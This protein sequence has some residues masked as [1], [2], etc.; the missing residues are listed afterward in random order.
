V[1]S[2][3]YWFAGE[4]VNGKFRLLDLDSCKEKVVLSNYD[5]LQM[6]AKAN[7]SLFQMAEEG[8]TESALGL[9]ILEFNMK[10][11]FNTDFHLD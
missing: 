1:A 3:T 9:V 5:V 6:V 4:L 7:S 8:T 11:V 2:T 10:T